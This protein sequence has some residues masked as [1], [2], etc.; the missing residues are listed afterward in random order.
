MNDEKYDVKYNLKNATLHHSAVGDYARVNNYLPAQAAQAD[1]GVA[2]LRQLFEQINLRLEALEAADREALIPTVQQTAQA[3]AEIQQGDASE[4][5]QSFLAARL[6]ILYAMRQDIGE[7]IITTLAD[8]A[9]GFALTLKKI[10][11]KAK[12]ELEIGKAASAE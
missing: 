2:E 6:K 4:A 5:K 3:T 1:P 7:V 10:A 9:A 12:A 8:P 11:Q